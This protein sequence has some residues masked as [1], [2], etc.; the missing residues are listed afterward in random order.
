[1]VEP[2]ST[3]GLSPLDQIRL[4]EAEITRRVVAAREYSEHN[5]ANARAQGTTLKKQA[6]ETGKREGLIR[7]K[8]TV[9]KAEEQAKVLIAKANHEAEKLRENGQA[10]MEQAVNTA[11]NIVL[12]L[13]GSGDT[14]E[15]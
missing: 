8:E 14:N 10:R 5:I 1:M 9:A 3:N 7:Y 2:T 13:K 15:S 4:V 12:G 6:E 11:L